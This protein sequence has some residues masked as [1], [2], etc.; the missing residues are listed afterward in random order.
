M[1]GEDTQ[2]FLHTEGESSRA[3]CSYDVHKNLQEKKFSC[4]ELS[5][6]PCPVLALSSPSEERIQLN[7][8][9]IDFGRGCSLSLHRSYSV[10]EIGKLQDFIW[11]KTVSRIR[12]QA[13]IRDNSDQSIV[14]AEGTEMMNDFSWKMIRV[15]PKKLLNDSGEYHPESH[16]QGRNKLLNRIMLEVLGELIKESTI[17]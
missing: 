10:T 7:R 3:N 2:V 5:D 11:C 4:K 17:F 1:A 6:K 15:W 14:K 13:I 8:A 16:F 9:L 12:C